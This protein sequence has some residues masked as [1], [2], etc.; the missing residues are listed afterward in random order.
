MGGTSVRTVLFVVPTLKG[1]GAERVI[2]TLLRQLDPARFRMVLAVVDTTNPV[3]RSDVPAGVE[4]VDL[5]STRLR[6]ALPG[7]LRVVWRVRPDLVFSTISYLN[8]ALIAMKPIMPRRSAFIG[9]ESTIVTELIKPFKLRA[10][11][12]A[13][14][15]AVYPRFDAVVCQSRYMQTD[16]VE[17]YGMPREKTVVINNPVDLERVTGALETRRRRREPGGRLRLVCA[18]RLYPVKGYD[19]LLD[20]LVLLRDLDVS[21]TIFGDGP[22]RAEVEARSAALGLERVVTLAGFH[23]N[24]FRQIAEADALVLSSRYE[25]F[26]NVVLEALACGIGVISTPA[27]G[28]VSEIL[29]GVAGCVLADAVSAEALARAIRAWASRPFEG[30][31]PSVLDKYQLGEIAER[32]AQLF[33]RVCTA[34]QQR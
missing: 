6:S 10:L 23:A 15:R 16:L 31:D 25:G 9:R 18:G 22:L 13:T 34:R 20:A 11:W 26:P 12:R 21:L 3:Y 14:Y 33:E 1:G 8:L 28:G 7:L 17:T 29:E 30:I 27:I 5:G 2:V 4:F 24:P 19:L 32:Y